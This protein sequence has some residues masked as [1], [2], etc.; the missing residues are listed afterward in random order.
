MKEQLE[1]IEQ[2]AAFV[3]YKTQLQE[4]VQKNNESKVVYQLAGEEGPDHNKTFFVIAKIDGNSY[5]PGKG[6][7]KKEAEQL[8]AKMALDKLKENHGKK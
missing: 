7:S 4:I 1:D 5:G 3:D 8:A 2:E 6:S